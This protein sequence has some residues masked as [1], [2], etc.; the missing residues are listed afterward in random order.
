MVSPL[1]P[2]TVNGDDLVLELAG[3]LGGLGLVL[4]GDGER[5][6]LVAGELPLARDVLG[7]DAHVVAVEGVGQ[8]VLDHGVDQLE[9]A[10][11]DAAAQMLGSA[12]PS[13]WIPGRR[14]R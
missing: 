3:L 9:V 12:A 4:R 2:L 14:R 10:H 8:A 5:V 6:L 1:R 13:T 7:G 11:L